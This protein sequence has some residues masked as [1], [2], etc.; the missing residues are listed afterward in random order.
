MEDQACCIRYVR[1]IN[2]GLC[3]EKH[4]RLRKL[5]KN[6]EEWLAYDGGNDGV[7]NKQ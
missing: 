6:H 2:M 5:Q 1:G 4:E 7:Q 3:E